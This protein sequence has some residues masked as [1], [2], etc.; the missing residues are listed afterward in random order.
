MQTLCDQT[1]NDLSTVEELREIMKDRDAELSY[2][3]EKYNDTYLAL[4]DCAK[5]YLSYHTILVQTLEFIRRVQIYEEGR[6]D[7]HDIMNSIK[8]LIND[9]YGKLNPE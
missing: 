2:Y 6:S 4:D 5:M 3:K 7:K 8:T 9:K 1:G